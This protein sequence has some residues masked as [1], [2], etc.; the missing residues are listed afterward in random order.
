MFPLVSCGLFINL[1]F[2]SCCIIK[3]V[4]SYLPFA[5]SHFQK[6]KSICLRLGILCCK[7]RIIFRL[8]KIINFELNSIPSITYFFE[9][10]GITPQITI[11]SV[12]D[13]NS[14]NTISTFD[15]HLDTQA[16]HMSHAKQ[17]PILTAIKQTVLSM[18]TPRLKYQMTPQS[19]GEFHF[20]SLIVPI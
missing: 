2:V 1:Y 8:C 9:K 15:T 18:H 4:Y 12:S 16:F 14:I 10:P 5:D 3:G 11:K 17:K 20:I 6:A 13:I 19:L 7:I